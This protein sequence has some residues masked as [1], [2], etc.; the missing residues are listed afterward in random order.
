MNEQKN[1]HFNFSII[2][3]I[4][5]EYYAHK[6]LTSDLYDCEKFALDMPY[7]YQEY[8]TF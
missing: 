2:L 6:K 1:K 5:V 3:H 8:V 7:F 4:L